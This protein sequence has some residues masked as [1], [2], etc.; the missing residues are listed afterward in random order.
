MHSQ[1]LVALDCI[2]QLT[3]LRKTHNAS[4]AIGAHWTRVLYSRPFYMHATQLYFPSFPAL[5]KLNLLQI[6]RII[7][8]THA[9]ISS[10]STL[11]PPFSI[12]FAHH[13]LYMEMISWHIWAAAL[14]AV[15][16]V[17]VQLR[18][19]S[20][21]RHIHKRYGTRY[22]LPSVGAV[23]LERQWTQHNLEYLRSKN[24]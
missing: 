12:T 1:L 21:Y 5:L 19:F 14:L 3:C 10:S 7:A 17:R 15:H 24:S 8:Q 11:V 13:R 18:R 23:Q 22:S 16:L 20:H 9:S 2:G 4:F 6:P